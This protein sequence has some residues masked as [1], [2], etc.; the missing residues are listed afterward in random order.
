MCKYP[1]SGVKYIK[2]V[3]LMETF[4]INSFWWKHIGVA[5]IK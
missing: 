3:V 2:L 5:S 1:R 4:I